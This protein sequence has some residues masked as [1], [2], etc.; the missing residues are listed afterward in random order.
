LGDD[1]GILPGPEILKKLSTAV[2]TDWDM[3]SVKFAF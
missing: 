3:L 1:N 2:P